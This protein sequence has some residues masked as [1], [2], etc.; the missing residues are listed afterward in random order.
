[1]VARFRE[2]GMLRLH[3]GTYVQGT[4]GA[5]VSGGPGPARHAGLPTNCGMLRRVGP[6]PRRA[7]QQVPSPP[8]VFLLLQ[9][10]CRRR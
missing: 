9:G 10:R 8:G 3:A 4:E 1:M 6:L 7:P 2:K 5:T